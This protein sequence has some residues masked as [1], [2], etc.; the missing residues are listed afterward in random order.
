MII[1]HTISLADTPGTLT[2]YSFEAL[3][4]WLYR[5]Q[6]M[7]DNMQVEEI[8]TCIIENPRIAQTWGVHGQIR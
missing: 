2:A 1:E 3:A 6:I 8:I 4:Q 7:F 5:G